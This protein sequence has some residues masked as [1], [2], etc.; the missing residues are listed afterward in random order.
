MDG[1]EW[2][3]WR[4]ECAGLTWRVALPD[5]RD[6]VVALFG[7]LDDRPDLFAPPVLI[8]VVAEDLGGSIVDAFYVE[9][10]A[11]IT[12]LTTNR[13]GFAA[14][15]LLVPAIASLLQARKVRVAQMSVP[16]RWVN[17]MRESMERMGFAPAS[18]QF[19][20]WVRKVLP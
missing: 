9:L 16:R 17:V 18:N 11:D 13:A 10:V 1:E 8:T 15:E 19:A 6:R 12:K 2:R 4:L 20:Q 3:D 5:D 14:A 7:E